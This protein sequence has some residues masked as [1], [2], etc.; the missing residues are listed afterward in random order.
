MI[1]GKQFAGALS[2][3]VFRRAAPPAVFVCVKNLP[4]AFCLAR[5]G[6]ILAVT[7]T[8]IAPRGVMMPQREAVPGP[9]ARH[10]S[11]GSRTLTLDGAHERHSAAPGRPDS[12]AGTLRLR[13]PQ[14]HSAG[15]NDV[16]PARGR[17]VMWADDTLDNEGMGKKKSKSTLY[18]KAS[19]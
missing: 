19:H 16:A 6:N 11:H 3:I 12:A 7:S 17:R 13:T 4:I 2:Y 9:S 8:C 15:D 10:E 14:S 5:C 1:L 18:E